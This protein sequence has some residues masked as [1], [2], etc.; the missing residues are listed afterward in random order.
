[1]VL[2]LKTLMYVGATVASLCVFATPATAQE[3]ATLATE[4]D[5]GNI[6]YSSDKR[7][8]VGGTK[9]PAY[10][11]SN[12]CEFKNTL[13]IVL[14]RKSSIAQVYV[15]AHDNVGNHTRARLM[16]YL[17]G[18][19]LGDQDVKA[20]GSLHRFDVNMDGQLVSLGTR[21][22]TDRPGGEEALVDQ[23]LILGKK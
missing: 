20:G 2:S 23:I 8:C 12:S 7:V 16:L 14:P 3:S 9:C 11:R 22:E 18:K 19:K 13:W 6:I 15:S 17:D 21:H 4:L 10:C 5:K 1:M